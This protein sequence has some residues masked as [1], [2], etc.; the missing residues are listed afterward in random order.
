MNG[1]DPVVYFSS[2]AEGFSP[3]EKCDGSLFS[4]SRSVRLGL[5]VKKHKSTQNRPVLK[6]NF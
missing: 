3:W 6:G 4:T 2:G 1:T 5:S